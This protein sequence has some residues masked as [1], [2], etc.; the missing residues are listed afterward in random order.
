M[1]SIKLSKI[2]YDPQYYPRVNGKEDWIT[3]LQYK[4]ALEADP[5]LGNPKTNPNAFPPIV[6][7]DLGKGWFLLIDGLHRIRAFA[8]V[9]IEMIWAIVERLPKSKWLARSVELNIPNGR[10][11]DNGDKLWVAQRLKAEGWKPRQIAGLLKMKVDTLEKMSVERVHK[12]RVSDAKKLPE[13]RANRKVNGN[14]FGFLKPPL[15]GTVGTN[16]AI[17]ALGSQHSLTSQ[18]VQQVLDA[19][20]AV[21]RSGVV[22]LTD[23]ETAKA[24]NEL[25]ELTGALVNS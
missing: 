13:G 25:H 21:F 18:R 8:A 22:D 16:R 9:G 6:V 5:S 15:A 12:L 7:V 2:K 1:R 23:E 10:R 20:L 14:H 4:E 24:V 19:A 17:A 11:L 3:V